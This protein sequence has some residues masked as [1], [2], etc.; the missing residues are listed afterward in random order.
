MSWYF[1]VL[2]FALLL[3]AGVAAFAG[4]WLLSASGVMLC[5]A[6]LTNRLRFGVRSGS[7]RLQLERRED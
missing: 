2:M 3:F 4:L 5:I 7:A 6:V 1:Y